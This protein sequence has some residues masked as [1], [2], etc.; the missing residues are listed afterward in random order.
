MASRQFE[1]LLDSK[2]TQDGI[3]HNQDKTKKASI[4]RQIPESYAS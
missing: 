3:L 1:G 4:D 2:K